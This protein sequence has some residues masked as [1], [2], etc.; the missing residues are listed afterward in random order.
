LARVAAFDLYPSVSNGSF[1]DGQRQIVSRLRPGLKLAE[2][3]LHGVDD[4][5]W[6]IQLNLVSAM[7]DHTMHAA[8][9]EMRQSLVLG[10]PALSIGSPE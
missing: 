2:H 8:R 10:E 6:L 3:L 7:L 9:S 4:R 1:Q 5:L